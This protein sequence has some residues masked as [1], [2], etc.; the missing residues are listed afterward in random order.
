MMAGFGWG[1]YSP[2]S[3]YTMMPLYADALQLQAIELNDTIRKS[4]YGVQLSNTRLRIFPV[5]TDDFNIYFHYYLKS[6][7]RNYLK[8]SD[9][10]I[11][12]ASNIP[13]GN[14]TYKHINSVGKQ[15]IRKYTLA[16]CK[17]LLGLIRGKFSTIPI[18][19]SELTLNSADL[20][21]QAQTEKEALITEI[22]DT[23]DQLSRQA[24]L[25]RKQAEAESLQIQLNK[26][27]LFIYTG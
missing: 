6:D 23:L 13:Y 24:Q 7:Q 5:P 14:L 20:L 22:K 1:G 26:I 12:D 16:L 9:G 21:T 2:G 3:S 10:L 17:E 8:Q 11:S 15:W 27:P 19:G 25:E 18:P 4:Q